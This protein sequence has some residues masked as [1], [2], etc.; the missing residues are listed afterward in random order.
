M[1]PDRKS[2]HKGHFARK[3]F[4]QHFLADVGVIEDIV[5]AIKPKPGQALVEIGP[6]L[7]AMTDPVVAEC[8]H[9]T[10]IDNLMLGRHQ[11]I[12]YGPAAAFMWLGKARRAELAHRRP[13]VDQIGEA[14]ANGDMAGHRL[15]LCQAGNQLRAGSDCTTGPGTDMSIRPTTTPW[16][17]FAGLSWTGSRNLPAESSFLIAAFSSRLETPWLPVVRGSLALTSWKGV[18]IW[19][20]KS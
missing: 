5:R 9:L 15:A 7:G 19:S 1:P 12:N 4:G 11:H 20:L 16:T 3:R 8:E 13:E 14:W 6:G 10:V 2:S 17:I 18:T